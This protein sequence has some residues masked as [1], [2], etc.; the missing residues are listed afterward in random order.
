[1]SDFPEHIG[2]DFGNHS[3]KAVELA[4]IETQKPKLVNFGSQATPQ[5]VINSEDETHQ[6]KL[7][8]AL[9]ELYS[10]SK[11]RN[12]NV[13]MALPEFSVFTRFAEFIG[14][15]ENE[16]ANA[17]YYEAKKYIPIPIEEVH[18]SF[19]KVGFDPER[20]AQKIL[21]VAAP[22]KIIEIYL[23]VADKAGLNPLAIETE[24]IALGRSMYRSTGLKQAIMLDFG[25]QSTDMSIMTEGNLVFSQSISIG[26]DV[27]TQ[28]I[29]NKFN[30]QY[31]QA[32]EYKRNYG[33]VK[34]NLEGKIFEVLKPVM[35]SIV[36][37]VQR[38][39][40]F[41]RTRTLLALPG[42]CLLSGDGSLLPGLSEFMTE[43]LGITCRVAD[44]WT[45]IQIDSKFEAV[46]SKSKPS[47]AVA[48]GLALKGE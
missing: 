2:L 32:E 29:I 21:L 8:D 22:K 27:L 24:S 20:N 37:E 46:L 15:K 26:S 19:M 45:N 6:S 35:D 5:G 40:E 34:T 47:F 11:L 4:D 1:M 18:T 28:S 38:G 16:I 9:K 12:K 25:A 3:V 33:L 13:V 41:Y 7:A 48:V 30:F 23:S 31:N 36:Q 43:A 14:I 39:M 44:P 17:V 42:E 10:N